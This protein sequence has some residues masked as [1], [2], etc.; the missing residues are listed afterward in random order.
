MCS[1]RERQINIHSLD[2]DNLNCPLLNKGKQLERQKSVSVSLKFRSCKF[3][4]AHPPRKLLHN[5][6]WDRLPNVRNRAESL[7]VYWHRNT[8]NINAKISVH[9]WAAWYLLGVAVIKINGCFS[10]W[11]INQLHWLVWSLILL[12]RDHRWNRYHGWLH[13]NTNPSQKGTFLQSP[14]CIYN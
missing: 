1:R 14:I 10:W 8:Q 9:S 3:S 4:V 13:F 11:V 6:W 12:M 7:C 5:L 2:L